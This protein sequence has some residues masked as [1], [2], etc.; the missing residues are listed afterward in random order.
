MVRLGKPHNDEAARPPLGQ[1]TVVL[2]IVS[3]ASAVSTATKASKLPSGFTVPSFQG[4]TV[5]PEVKYVS[6]IQI[7]ATCRAKERD[8]DPVSPR[9]V[10]HRPLETECG[11]PHTRVPNLEEAVLGAKSG[12][13][14]DSG[15]GEP[16]NMIPDAT[17]APLL[18]RK[19]SVA[20]Q[21]TA[22]LRISSLNAPTI[23]RASHEEPF[24]SV[25]AKG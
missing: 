12:S 18:P 20:V 2:R 10:P 9:V 24:P 22:R 13:L 1:N 3:R 4:R 14:P 16:E 17:T 6:L 11:E 8:T 5:E 19:R 23:S 7:P 21:M 15:E 25:T